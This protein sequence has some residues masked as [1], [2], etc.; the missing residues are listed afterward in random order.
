MKVQGNEVH[1]FVI[2]LFYISV[3]I[4]PFVIS[5][6]FLLKIY[7]LVFFSNHEWSCI[8][9]FYRFGNI[10]IIL[11]IIIYIHLYIYVNTFMH[12]YIIIFK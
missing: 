6:T 11:Y 5:Y 7:I 9:A 8:L 1:A 10:F 4:F 12:V 3:F 2:N